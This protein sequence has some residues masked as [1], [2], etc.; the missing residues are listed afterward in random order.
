MK[1][2]GIGGKKGPLGVNSSQLIETTNMRNYS[3]PKQNENQNVVLM[4]YI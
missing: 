1:N 4:Q 3:L 2:T